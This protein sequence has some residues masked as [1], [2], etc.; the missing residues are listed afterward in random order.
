[1]E[2]IEGLGGKS[3]ENIAKSSAYGWIQIRVL[4]SYE[5]PKN[6][7]HPDVSSP[8]HFHIIDTYLAKAEFNSTHKE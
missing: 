3:Q 7:P 2:D 6:L 4:T 8:S 1:M 5:Y